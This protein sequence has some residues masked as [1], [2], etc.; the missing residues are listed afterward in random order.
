LLR[1]SFHPDALTSFLHRGW[2]YEVKWDG[3]RAQLVKNGSRVRLI[4]RILK[5][6]TADYPHIPAAA[7]ALT[8]QDAIID[9]E[10]VALDLW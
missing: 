9:G 10:I 1:L 4:S 2:S 8:R 6:L 7:A 5:D 3:Y